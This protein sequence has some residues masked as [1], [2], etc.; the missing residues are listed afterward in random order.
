V[1]QDGATHHGV[2]DLAYLRC[3]PNLIVF[4]PRNEVELRNIMFT[5]QSGLRHPI[6]VRYPR[7]RGRITDWNVPFSK[8]LIGKGIKLK[9]GRSAAVLTIGSM[10]NNVAEAIENCDHP[11]NISHYDM[12]FVKPLDEDLLHSIFKSY[13]SIIT[14][15]DGVI[16]GGFGS[17]IVEFA[18]KYCYNSNV[19]I[20]GIPDQFI[21]HGSVNE[22]Q[23][24]IG[25]DA[26]SL[27]RILNSR[28]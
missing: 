13:K 2:F 8:I 4:A 10:A 14:V 22:L 3:I 17:A 27:T 6:A 11:G 25:L 24:A 12:R 7:G 9:A 19:K 16:N 5:A 15:E 28:A 18:S 26:K 23:S 1:G 20:L 21:Q